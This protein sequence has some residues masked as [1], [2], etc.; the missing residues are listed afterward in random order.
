VVAAIGGTT[1]APLAVTG[2]PAQCDAQLLMRVDR[3]RLG[4]DG[5][6]LRVTGRRAPPLGSAVGSDAVA[7]TTLF[8]VPV[9]SGGTFDA[10]AAVSSVPRS[11]RM[12]ALSAG[13]RWALD[14][15]VPIARDRCAGAATETSSGRLDD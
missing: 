10:R 3:A 14:A 9:R 15:L 13:H 7:G 12:E 5:R 2:A 8:S 11:L 6:T 1:S 4:C